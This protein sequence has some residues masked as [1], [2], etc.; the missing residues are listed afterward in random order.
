MKVAEYFLLFLHTQENLTQAQNRSPQPCQR[1][2]LNFC[3][4]RNRRNWQLT[5]YI[6]RA[7]R[8]DQN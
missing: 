1:T 3:T 5:N 4:S 2:T 6:S 8:H 7:E